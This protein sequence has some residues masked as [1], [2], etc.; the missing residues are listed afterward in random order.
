MQR[1]QKFRMIGLAGAA[2]LAVAVPLGAAIAG[3]ADTLPAVGGGARASDAGPGRAVTAEKSSRLTNDVGLERRANSG[4]S[5]NGP[6]SPN[7]P[8]R[9]ASTAKRQKT[10]SP[11]GELDLPFLSGRTSRCGPELASPQGIEAQTCVLAEG[12]RTWARTYY[13]NLTGGPLRAVLALLRPDGRTVQVHCEVP[14]AD[15]PGVCETPAGATVRTN[16]QAYG[17]VAE[18]SDARG[19]RLLLR[20]GSN[21]APEGSGSDH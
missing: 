18:I 8:S 17:A 13:R 21:S 15:E 12:G 11:L 1:A 19:E 2:V 9:P 20:S 7:G 3:P 10:T 16:R 4:K 14:A 6:N 5:L